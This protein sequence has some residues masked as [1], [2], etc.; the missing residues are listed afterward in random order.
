MEPYIVAVLLQN[1][2]TR[3][4]NQVLDG[5]LKWKRESSGH[6]NSYAAALANLR[7]H[8][9]LDYPKGKQPKGKQIKVNLSSAL[10][11]DWQ[12]RYD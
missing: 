12:R 1:E 9:V 4:K 5:V 2:G 8:G 7:D 10:L 6:R 11:L 3:T